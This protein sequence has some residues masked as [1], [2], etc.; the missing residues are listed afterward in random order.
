M[1]PKLST[2]LLSLLIGVQM[3]SAITLPE[4]EKSYEGKCTEIVTEKVKSIT[5]LQE[6]YLAAL[7]KIE[8]KYQRAGRL[9][10]VLLVKKEIQAIENDQW[11]LLQLPKQIS[12]ETST[13]RKIYLRKHIEI[14]QQAA[15][16]LVQTADTMAKALDAQV[17]SL[18]KSGDL[19]NAKLAQ[20]IQAEIEANPIISSARKLVKN[21]RSDGSSRPALR[22]RRSGDNME[23]LVSY[24]M[25]G[26]VS[27]DSPISN[28]EETDKTIGD[29]AAQ[30]LGEFVGGKDFDADPIVTFE[31]VFD[32]KDL[33]GI[34]LT[35]IDS[36]FGHKV[37]DFVG[38]A[39]SIK[40][41][42]TNPYISLPTPVPSISVGGTT[43]ITFHYFIPRTNKAI[44]GFRLIQGTAGGSA[45][46]GEDFTTSGKWTTQTISSEPLSEETR[47]LIYLSV[48]PAKKGE[49]LSADTVVLG[50]LKI[51]QIKF[52]AYITQRLGENGVIS[53]DFKDP[54]SQPKL[55]SNGELIPQ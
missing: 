41:K 47:L 45:F 36:D 23:V 17:T 42:A 34:N 51:E 7:K 10:E 30:L 16:D 13:P 21:V 53:E 6:S 46:G 50:E 28:V 48:D 2:I 26:K 11:P 4:L 39:L 24:D 14:E 3:V 9:N 20:Q 18:T 37:E 27:L 44:T 52:T 55:V 29:T 40:E 8:N 31:K 32:D 19:Q 54:A 43:Q 5:A 38:V 35:E 15:K 12:M 33:A 49:P 25:R 1:N 22:I